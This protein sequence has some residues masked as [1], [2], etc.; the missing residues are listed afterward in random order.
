PMTLESV[1]SLTP[2]LAWS[3]FVAS[4]GI[5]Q[6][7]TVIV[8]NLDFVRTIQKM[9]QKEPVAAWKSYLRWQFLRAIAPTLPKA[10]AEESFAFNQ[11]VLGGKTQDLPR[12]KRAVAWTDELLGEDLGQLYVARKFPPATKARVAAMI[13]NI[14]ATLKAR[15]T[16]LDWLS[17]TAKQEA[18]HK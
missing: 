2:G 18:L 13:A 10:F 7:G 16:T 12:W 3:K 17:A 4:L 1:D 9:L 6:P 14:V 11:R 8:T 5:R 15:I